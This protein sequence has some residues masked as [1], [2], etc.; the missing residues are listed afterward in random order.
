MSQNPPKRP[1]FAPRN[2][3]GWF[4][5]SLMWVLGWLPRPV[6]LALVWPLGP[7]LHTFARR[8]REIAERNLERCFP[9]WS[10]EQRSAMVRNTFGALARMVAETAWC[11]SGPMGR[12]GKMGTVH[13]IENLRDAEERGNGVLLVTGHATCLEIGGRILLTETNYSAVYRPLKSEVVEWYQNR[14][15]L[16][17]AD[18]MISKRNALQAVKLLKRGFA[19]REI[20]VRYIPRGRAEGKKIYWADGFISLWTVFKLRLT[21]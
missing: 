16:R 3:G 12:F 4:S 10:P 18:S 20:P 1:S 8:R 19:I 13:G 6:G 9:D 2:W 15:R 5:V 21:D 17:Y 7:L 11:W 14:G